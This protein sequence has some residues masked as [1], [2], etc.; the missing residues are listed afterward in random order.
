MKDGDNMEL[1]A[2]AINDWIQT[3]SVGMDVMYEKCHAAGSVAARV[4]F[5][6]A[7]IMVAVQAHMDGIPVDKVMAMAKTIIEDSMRQCAEQDAAT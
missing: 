2:R 7:C 5:T 3:A 6:A 4:R 1:R